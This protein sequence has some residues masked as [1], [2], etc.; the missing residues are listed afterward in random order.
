MVDNPKVQVY[1]MFG[2]VGDF[3]CSKGEKKEEKPHHHKEK[4]LKSLTAGGFQMIP[5]TLA[6]HAHPVAWKP[7][8]GHVGCG[9][10]LP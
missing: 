7:L 2:Y 8:L 10:G 4:P 6:L 5:R 9:E 1:R 3:R